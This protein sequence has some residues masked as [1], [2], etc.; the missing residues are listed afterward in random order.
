MPDRVGAVHRLAP[1]PGVTPCASNVVKSCGVSRYPDVGIPEGGSA[2]REMAYKANLGTAHRSK[3]AV[4]ESPKHNLIRRE[5][6][7]NPEGA[8][9]SQVLVEVI[10]R[11]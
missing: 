9:R 7:E 1:R 4:L 10:G 5:I 11:F 8:C 3:S 2:H 6:M